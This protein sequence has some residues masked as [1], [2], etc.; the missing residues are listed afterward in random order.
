[1]FVWSTNCY[2]GVVFFCREFARSGVAF[3][4]VVVAVC[5]NFFVVTSVLGGWKSLQSNEALLGF[6]SSLESMTMTMRDVMIESW[7]I[8]NEADE[9]E[10][11]ETE[12]DETVAVEGDA[13][14][15]EESDTEAEHCD[16]AVHP[17][18]D[19]GFRRLFQPLIRV[20]PPP[21]FFLHLSL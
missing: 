11:E 14:K 19:E 21:S 6:A 13:G 7:G 15:V 8:T 3:V 9:D 5:D 18:C 10:D 4:V 12:E 1:V 17:N 20:S 16:R 2:T